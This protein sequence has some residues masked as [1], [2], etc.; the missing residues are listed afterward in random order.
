[1]KNF[2]LN[3]KLAFIAILLGFFALF[4]GNPYK[5][6]LISIDTKELGLIV[7]KA[8]DH[9]TVDQLADWLIQGKADFRLIDLRTEKEFSEYHIP[10]SENITITGLEKAEI[11]KSEKIILYSEGGIHSAQAWMLLKA[12]GYKGVYFLTG[13]L[14]EWKDRILFP[15]LSENASAEEKSK[16]EKSKEISKFFVGTPMVLSG[17]ETQTGKPMETKTETQKIEMPKMESPSG[18]QSPSGT[19]KKKKEGC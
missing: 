1:M 4:L 8:E 3:K 7:E 2:S 14:D 10:N 9:I 15:K 11:P 5:G 13:G 16:F 17:T 18:T 12:K 19:P 6:N